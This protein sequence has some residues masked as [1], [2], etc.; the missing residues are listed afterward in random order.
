MASIHIHPKYTLLVELDNFPKDQTWNLSE[1]HPQP[2]APRP[3]APRHAQDLNCYWGAG[4]AT[5]EGKDFVGLLPLEECLKES[6][7]IRC[8]RPNHRH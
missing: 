2:A 7:W 1:P 5:A 6:E 4:A 3:A 8:I